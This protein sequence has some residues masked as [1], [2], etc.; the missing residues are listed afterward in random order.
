MKRSIAAIIIILLCLATDADSEEFSILGLEFPVLK[1]KNW[2][3]PEDKLPVGS[4]PVE[5]D[6]VFFISQEGQLDSMRFKPENR[7]N[8]LDKVSKSLN[9]LTFYP[10]LY[11]NIPIPFIL[12]ARII[13]NRTGIIFELPYDDNT[14]QKNRGLINKALELNGFDIPLVEKFPAYY[15]YMNDTLPDKN[16]LFAVFE[17]ELDSMGNYVEFR[18]YAGAADQLADLFSRLVLY[19]DFLPASYGGKTKTST[20]YLTVRL[21]NGIRYPTVT[22]PPKGNVGIKMPFDYMRVETSLYPD[23]IINPPIPINIPNGIHY[24]SEPTSYIDTFDIVVTIDTSGNI[25]KY[26]YRSPIKSSTCKICDMVINRLLFLPARDLH[27]QVVEYE[28]TLQL[29]FDTSKNIR[30]VANWLPLEAQKRSD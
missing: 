21:F 22:W 17:I 13:F 28:G 9:S 12:P 7:K 11:E 18:N 8:F 23:S 25:R 10:A 27:N 15:F 20:L 2:L 30:I 5:I 3:L 16:Y 1:H 24:Y 19:T 26:N 6:L 14:C 29:I 4:I